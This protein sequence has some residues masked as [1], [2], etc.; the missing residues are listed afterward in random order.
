MEPVLF[1]LKLLP[2]N[3]GKKKKKKKKKKKRMNYAIEHKPLIYVE[4]DMFACIDLE[5]EFHLKM[6]EFGLTII[7]TR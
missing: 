4:I 6:Q 7:S 3:P 5:V 2:F 1:L